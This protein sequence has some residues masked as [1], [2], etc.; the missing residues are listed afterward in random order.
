MILTLATTSSN[1]YISL[2]DDNIIE[3][4]V[5]IDNSENFFRPIKCSEL[6]N[7]LKSK[8]WGNFGIKYIS[9]YEDDIDSTVRAKI[10]DPSI[11]SI[12]SEI[13]KIL[14]SSVKDRKDS[15]EIYSSGYKVSG[16][17][18]NSEERE[19]IDTAYTSVFGSMNEVNDLYFY[20]PT[21]ST[22][23][24]S[25]SAIT[26]NLLNNDQGLYVNTLNF[27]KLINHAV[28]PDLSAICTINIIYSKNSDI[29]LKDTTFEV[30]NYNTVEN[31]VSKLTESIQLEYFNGELKVIPLKE[32]ITECI[33]G[34]CT[35]TYGNLQSNTNRFR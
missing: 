22:I 15:E 18:F 11:S 7:K 14:T 13:P 26:F 10:T 12:S 33:F 1:G 29:Y 21:N 20:R 3:D 32:D 28:R 5:I 25:N 35:I 9:T 30:F 17:S 4:K 16:N 6:Y 8:G 23:D 27:G 19:L 2:L 24:L 31:F 34:N